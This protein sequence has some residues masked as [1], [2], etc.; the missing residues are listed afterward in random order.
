MP[1]YEL[2]N[3]SDPYTFEAE[4]IEVAGAAVVYLSTSYGATEVG[5]DS[6]QG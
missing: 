6:D 5:C 4:N 2:N 1:I 3:P